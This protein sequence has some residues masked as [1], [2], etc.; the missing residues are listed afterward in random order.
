MRLGK[1]NSMLKTAVDASQEPLEQVGGG[2]SSPHGHGV[3]MAAWVVV[4][5]V[6]LGGVLRRRLLLAVRVGVRHIWGR[7]VNRQVLHPV[8]TL[9]LDVV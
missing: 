1:G 2:C 8:L 9:L 3:H 6:Q 7:V 5:G 4:H